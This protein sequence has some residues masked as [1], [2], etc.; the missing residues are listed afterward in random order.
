MLHFLLGSR[1]TLHSLDDLTTRLRSFIGQAGDSSCL[2]GLLL[3]VCQSVSE[4][5]YTN[6][7]DRD[8]CL[9]PVAVSAAFLKN[10][11]LFNTV[12]S[13]IK[14]RFVKNYY[15]ALGGLNYFDGL[16]AEET[17]YVP[18]MP[19]SNTTKSVGSSINSAITKCGKIH[20]IHENLNAFRDGF[21][22]EHPNRSDQLE[23]NSLKRWLDALLY[24]CLYNPKQVCE[25][26]ATT[27]LKIIV[28]REGAPFSQ[29]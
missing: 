11:D 1:F 9:G 4:R 26:D 29:Q 2:Q 20:Q 27:L 23:V 12:T 3:Q 5:D 18:S 10:L 21:F 16:S 7:E 8:M 13:Q 24:S 22:K 25:Q 17:T 28:E 14:G 19:S 15:F 6:D